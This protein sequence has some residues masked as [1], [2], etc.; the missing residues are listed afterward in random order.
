MTSAPAPGASDGSSTE[1]AHD[2]ARF[3]AGDP[4]QQSSLV[5]PREWVLIT[6]RSWELQ[7]EV[8]AERL[9]NELHARLARARLA[10][11]V[12][13]SRLKAQNG[14]GAEIRLISSPEESIL[15]AGAGARFEWGAL[16][17]CGSELVSVASA[18]AHGGLIE[19]I[20]IGR[21]DLKLTLDDGRIFQGRTRVGLRLWRGRPRRVVY[22]PFVS[23]GNL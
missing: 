2:R 12:W 8:L 15:T 17:D 5:L 20:R 16:P 14:Q 9:A 21:A 3:S 18:I 1:P 4:A 13:E 10:A 7:S 23:D 19:S 22:P 11:K 6:T